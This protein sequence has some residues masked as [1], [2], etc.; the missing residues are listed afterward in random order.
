MI[1]KCGGPFHFGGGSISP[2]VGSAEVGLAGAGF[3]FAAG[4]SELAIG[5]VS[6]S[7]L[8]VAESLG[9]DSLGVDS[10]GVDS[11]GVDS[12]GGWGFCIDSV[13]GDQ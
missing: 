10:L 2:P 11:L 5:V 12:L 4:S 3:G 6:S 8:P 13:E 9:V 1:S 7:L